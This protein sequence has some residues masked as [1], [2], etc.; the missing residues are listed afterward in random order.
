M[1]RE[2]KSLVLSIYYEDDSIQIIETEVGACQ[3]IVYK[4]FIPPVVTG[5]EI[6]INTT[7]TELSLGSGGFDIVKANCSGTE[8]S[9]GTK[10]DGH[11]MKLRYSPMQHSVLAIEAQE[12]PYHSL[13]Q[14]P[15]LMKN[16]QILLAEL[17]SM[18]PVAFYVSKALNPKL[19]VCV[20]IDDQASLPLRISE[21]M[22]CLAQEPGLTT[23]TVGQAFGGTYEAITI[24]SALQF[25]MEYLKADII[26]ISVG[27]GVVGTGTP[28]GFTGMNLANW[29]N[30]IGA[31]GGRPVW[32]PRL[33]FAE[34]RNRHYGISHHTLTP[35]SQFT[36]VKSILTFPLL[37]DKQRTIIENQLEKNP[38]KTSHYINWSDEDSSL[39]VEKALQLSSLPIRTMGREYKDDPAF[40]L[41]VGE[42]VRTCVR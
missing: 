8:Y 30:T 31:L 24:P 28:Y 29:A 17:H 36:F 23:I 14:H 27:P 15:F 38:M 7:A 3:A 34:E 26:L 21:Q 33:S 22:R 2:K 35:L 41:A 11:I 39:I 13:F 5:D 25:S 20:I 10:R 6:L 1:Y 32:I 12:S 16:K 18:I 42:A 19:S 37:G 9:Y 40:F 4:T